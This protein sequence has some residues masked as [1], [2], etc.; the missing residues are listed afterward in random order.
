[1]KIDYSS[2]QKAVSQL[3]K[4]LSFLN[5]AMSKENADLREQFRAATIQAFEYTYELGIK[6]LKRQLEQILATPIELEKMTFMNFIR[7]AYEAGLVDNVPVY[8]IFREMRN[9]TSHTYNEDKAE[10]ILSVIETFLN[11][12][13]FI[14]KEIQFRNESD[15]TND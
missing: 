1:M 13:R 4:S 11:E 9:I 3:E 5:S 6:L 2:F 14:L 8:K 7:T 12:M 10:E 15:E